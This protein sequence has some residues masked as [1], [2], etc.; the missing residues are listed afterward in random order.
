MPETQVELAIKL[1]KLEICNRHGK[2]I[3]AA[4]NCKT[5]KN[6]KFCK[7]YDELVLP[8]IQREEAKRIGL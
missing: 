4:Y 5:C 7:K 2:R 3:P 1:V 8:I 6:S